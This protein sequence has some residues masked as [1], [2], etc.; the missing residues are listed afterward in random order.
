MQFTKTDFQQTDQVAEIIKFCDTADLKTLEQIADQIYRYQ[1]FLISIFLGFKDQVDVYQHDEILRILLIIWLFFKDHKNVKHTQI[2]QKQFETRQRKN[3]AFL[4][5]LGGESEQVQKHTT[6]DNLGALKSKALFTA[7]L[8][9][10]KQ[11]PA[12]KTL[13]PQLPG[14]ILVGMK[15]LIEAFEELTKPKRRKFARR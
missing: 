3:A 12:L 6:A 5:Y 7:V 15:S 4:N 9:K 2:T 1:P 13:E 14:I 10:I 11:G 8:F